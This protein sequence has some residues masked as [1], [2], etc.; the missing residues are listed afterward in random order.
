MMTYEKATT[1]GLVQEVE[2]VLER[3]EGALM[4]ST[5]LG[6]LEIVKYNIIQRHTQQQEEEDDEE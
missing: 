2:Q 1:A 5:V 6:C 4:I 3:Y